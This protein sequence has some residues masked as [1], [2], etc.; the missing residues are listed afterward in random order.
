M[1]KTTLAVSILGVCGLSAA[2]K[3]NLLFIFADDYAQSREGSA[4][5]GGSS[6]EREGA[7]YGEAVIVR[8]PSGGVERPLWK[9]VAGVGERD[10]GVA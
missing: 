7:G 9:G 2:A 5:D 3:T 4:G 10:G 1:L 6:G 8:A